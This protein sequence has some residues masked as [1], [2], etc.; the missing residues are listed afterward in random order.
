MEIIKHGRKAYDMLYFRCSFCGCQFREFFAYCDGNKCKCP[1]CGTMADGVDKEAY[2]FYLQHK[3]SLLT[4]V[5]HTNHELINE[6]TGVSKGYGT[7][8]QTKYE[9]CECIEDN[10]AVWSDGKCYYNGRNENDS[11]A[12]M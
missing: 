12:K 3:Q 11:K 8:I 2:D 7:V 5:E 10:C 9:Y 1:E 4:Q 6:E